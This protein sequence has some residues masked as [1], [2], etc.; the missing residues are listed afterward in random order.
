MHQFHRD[1]LV[2]Q[3]PTWVGGEDTRKHSA[4]VQ[5]TRQMEVMELPRNGLNY[6]HVLIVVP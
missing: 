1:L 6:S 2:K 5:L 4:L 3:L